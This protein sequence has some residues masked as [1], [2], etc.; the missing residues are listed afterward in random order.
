MRIQVFDDGRPLRGALS[1]LC[2]STEWTAGL[3]GRW[4]HKP[5]LVGTALPRG[6]P[7]GQGAAAWPPR[8]CG[9]SGRPEGTVRCPQMRL[10]PG[11]APLSPQRG[12]ERDGHKAQRQQAGPA[13]GSRSHT[14]KCVGASRRP[15]NP[16]G[17]APEGSTRGPQRGRGRAF[18]TDL[19]RDPMLQAWGLSRR[20][21]KLEVGSL[22]QAVLPV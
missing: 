3:S 1:S 22:S 13:P 12:R 11:H 18:P 6:L 19:P 21:A 16:D 17:R 5:R 7:R 2:V 20:N 10:G 14:G 9:S 8:P 15:L 4:W